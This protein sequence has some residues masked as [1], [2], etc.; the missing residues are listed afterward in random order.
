MDTT[1]ILQDTLQSL[2]EEIED[3]PPT[4]EAYA[5]ILEPSLFLTSLVQATLVSA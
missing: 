1:P 3:A 2:I 5:L 4:E